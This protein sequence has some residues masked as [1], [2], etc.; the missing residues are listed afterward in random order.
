LE[1]PN[2]S[3]E[4]TKKTKARVPNLL[5]DCPKTPEL[6]TQRAIKGNSL[7]REVFTLKEEITQSF[8]L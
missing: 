3:I 2:V 8:S 4:I 1:Y 6:A 7:P 5:S